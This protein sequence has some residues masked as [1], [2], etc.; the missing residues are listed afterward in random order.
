MQAISTEMERLW[1]SH[2][3]IT[4]FLLWQS[5]KYPPEWVIGNFYF[6]VPDRL[7]PTRHALEFVLRRENVT[8]KT[9][10]KKLK[11]RY[12]DETPKKKQGLFFL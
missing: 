1:E 8:T 11:Y 10:L 7:L 2:L 4:F 6:F 5:P 3:Y 9:L 12:I